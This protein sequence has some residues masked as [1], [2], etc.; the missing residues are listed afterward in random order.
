MLE[1]LKISFKQ[2][3]YWLLYFL[4]V[5][6]LFLLF[7]SSE[8]KE[9]TNSHV[10]YSFVKGLSMNLAASAY[11]SVLPVLILT[12]SVFIKFSILKVLKG[13]NFFFLTCTT[14]I[15]ITDL[16]LYKSWG[17]KINGRAIW[18]LQFPESV[19]NSAGS[20]SHLIYMAAI[21]GLGILWWRIYK[22]IMHSVPVL[23][24]RK[25]SI[26]LTFM[27]VAVILFL[28]LRGGLNGKP[29]SR[30]WSYYSKYPALNYAAVNGF[31]N[32]FDVLSH[33]KPQGNPYNYFNEKQ[34]KAFQKQLATA[35]NSDSVK[36]CINNRPNVLFIY[37]ESW[38]ADVVGSIGGEKSI[39]PGFDSLTKN[40]LLFSNF[41]STG[42]RTEQGLMATLSGFPAQA[43]VYPMEE[44][45]RFE[46]YPNL[47]SLFDSLGYYTSYFTGGNPEF[48]N[49]NSYLLQAGIKKINSELLFNAKKRSAWGA[50]DEETFDWV[51]KKVS[52]QPQPFFSTLVTLTSH[53]WFEA[54]VNKL[55]SDNDP[56]AA[57][58]K[59]TVHYTDS[60]L[61]DFIEKASQKDWYQN[62]LIVIMADHAC[63][64]PLS[65]QIQDPGR[66]HIPM[67][68]TG[69][70][71]K[72]RWKGKNIENISGHLH[73]PAILED[74]LKTNQHI[75]PLSTNPL[76]EP[77][78]KAY[79]SYDHGFGVI[80]REG[81]L[82]YDINLAKVTSNP[83]LDK[84]SG[85]EL[86]NYGK[87]IIQ[88]S[89]QLKSEYQIQKKVFN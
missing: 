22:K 81:S 2:F 6:S 46:N 25:T 26:T 68:I 76:C 73:I 85:F 20:S 59:N 37:L 88:A 11:L 27:L 38:G 87:F 17:S 16:A 69:G 4:I 63:S 57:N 43:Q 78:S 44:M 49:T 50:L 3:L 31:W 30:G 51:L 9:A 66:Y 82:V 64:Y 65:R 8:L 28:T 23:S 72:P 21:L 83:G 70:A 14:L 60:C 13:I 61:F 1:F 77:N 48:A 12:L 47:I 79:Y 34:L 45:E 7:F 36:L 32:F 40:G 41:Y 53:E 10:L 19:V 35:Q 56:V 39:T 55:F 52:T 54:R 74:E 84:N 18:Y 5:Q 75:F 24:Q 67:M 42:F 29:L 33:Y 80:S 15:N 89:A 86:L 62:T 58:Y 71:L